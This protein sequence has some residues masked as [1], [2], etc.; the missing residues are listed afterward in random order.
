[1]IMTRSRN[2]S[3]SGSP[4]RCGAS[5]I[6]RGGSAVRRCA[7]PVCGGG[8]DDDSSRSPSPLRC[9]SRGRMQMPCHR[10]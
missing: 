3:R 10:C 9:K 6:R 7:S 4:V 2:S 5:P 8:D 1:M